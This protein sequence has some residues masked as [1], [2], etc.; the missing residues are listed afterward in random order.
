MMQE[1]FETRK[2][3]TIN[4]RIILYPIFGQ[5]IWKSWWNNLKGDYLKIMEENQDYILLSEE[6]CMLFFS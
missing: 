4:R 6:F 3:F 1:G 2:I 5:N